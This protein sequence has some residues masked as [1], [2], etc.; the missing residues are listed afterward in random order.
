M[1]APARRS[2][3]PRAT[4][5][6]LS[7]PLPSTH[8]STN[9]VLIIGAGIIGAAVAWQAL[10]GGQSVTYLD[11]SPGAGATFAAAGMLAP[12]TEAT[13]GEDAL[14]ALCVAS[15]SLWPA[16]AAELADAAGMDLGF[17]T[18]GTLTVGYDQADAAQLDRLHAL[19]TR[20]GLRSEPITVAQA[21]EREPFLGPQLSCALWVAGDHQVDP[22]AVHRALLAVLAADPRATFIRSSATELLLGRDGRAIGAT[23]AHGGVHHA[24]TVVLA[25][26]T[27]SGRLVAPMRHVRLPVRAVTGQ[28]LRLRTSP[29]FDLA[30]VVRGTVQMRPIYIVPRAGGDVVVGAT[31]EE[32]DAED[33]ASAGGVFALLRDARALVPGIDELSFVEVTNRG[34]PGTPDSLPLIGETGVPGLLAATGHFRNGI[35]LTPLTAVAVGGLLGAAPSDDPDLAAVLGAA[36]PRRFGPETTR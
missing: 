11:P 21:R 13:V 27:A 26:G 18:S 35:L 20:L 24:G 10:R 7:P 17:E 8:P 34:R 36:D 25:A 4:S 3:A 2:S 19:H 12:V 28:T 32:R 15:A 31:S 9:D 33:M 5:P 23:D 30:H 1:R 29:G 16:F 6:Q 14:T 22:R